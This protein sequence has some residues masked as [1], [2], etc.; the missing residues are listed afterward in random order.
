MAKKVLSAKKILAAVEADELVG[1]CVV[2]GAESDGLVEPD[3]RK[4]KCG[5]CGKLAVYGAEELMLM[6]YAG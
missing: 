5:A 1:F 2:C 3:A 4:Y 6:G